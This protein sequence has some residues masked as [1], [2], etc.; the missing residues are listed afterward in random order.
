MAKAGQGQGQGYGCSYLQLQNSLSGHGQMVLCERLRG[1]PK[2]EARRALQRSQLCP[3]IPEDEIEKPNWENC[4]LYMFF[5][6]GKT[7]RFYALYFTLF[8]FHI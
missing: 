3:E 5:L 2:Q 8:I 1:L 7:I 4:T 6:L